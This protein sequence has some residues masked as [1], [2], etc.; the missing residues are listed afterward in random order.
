MAG[1]LTGL[2]CSSDYETAPVGSEEPQGLYLNAV[3]TGETHVSPGALLEALQAIERARGRE[4][5]FVNAPRTLDLDIVLYGDIVLDER[6]LVVPH[7]RFRVRRF[8]LDP[9]VEIAPDV[10]DPVTGLTMR[11]LRAAYLSSSSGS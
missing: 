2:R 5:P 3:V 8:V 6:H 9:L 7:P 11:A 4:R 10:R 1:L